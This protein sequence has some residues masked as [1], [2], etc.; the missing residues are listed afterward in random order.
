MYRFPQTPDDSGTQTFGGHPVT[1]DIKPLRRP[2]CSCRAGKSEDT[3]VV[4][5]PDFAG[6]GLPFFSEEEL[7]YLIRWDRRAMIRRYIWRGFL[8]AIAIAS[9]VLAT[10]IVWGSDL[11]IPNKIAGPERSLAGDLVVLKIN[12]SVGEDR[13]WAVDGPGDVDSHY[14]VVNDK[15]ALVFASRTPGRY[16]FV[17]AIGEAGKVSQY[18]HVLQNGEEGPGPDPIPPGKRW[19]LILGETKTFTPAQAQTIQGLRRYATAKGHVLSVA[20]PD[21]GLL[22]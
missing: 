1:P 19:V 22:Q 12:G 21:Q 5:T 4:A 9:I 11:P 10:S 16:L 14:F 2:A 3:F 8:L 18:K 17:L 7:D 6:T 20:D 13:S 15:E